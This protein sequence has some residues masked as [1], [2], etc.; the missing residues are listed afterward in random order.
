MP[1]TILLPLV[2]LAAAVPAARGQ[3]WTGPG[4]DWNTPANWTPAAVPNSPTAVVTFTE[5]AVGPVN[6]SAS[7]QAQSLTFANPT[8]SYTLTS[9]G[10]V[11]LGGV[12]AVTMAAGVTAVQ[13]INLAPV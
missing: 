3:T 9:G 6:I 2:L 10:G 1:R 4:T 8:G 13:S 12:R 7:V 11:T 5:T